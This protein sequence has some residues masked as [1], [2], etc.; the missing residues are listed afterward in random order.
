MEE[1]LSS[2][3]MIMDISSMRSRAIELLKEDKDYHTLLTAITEKDYYYD[4]SIGL[5]SIKELV[6]QT[7]VK[8]DLIRKQL[9]QIYE[10]LL[11]LHEA[12]KPFQ[13]HKVNFSFYIKGYKNVVFMETN[14]L[15]VMPRVGESTEIPFFKA[16]LGGEYF[17]VEKIDH[18]LHD[19]CHTIQFKL[20]PGEYNIYWH[21][22]KDKAKE[23]GE[24]DIHDLIYESDFSLKKKLNIGKHR[25]W[26]IS[27]GFY[28]NSTGFLPKFTGF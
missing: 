11:P 15:S 20:K 4:D 13:F 8:Y 18:I 7:G 19:T 22:Q 17:Y 23:E 16:Y 26:K 10:D 28:P 5:P 1:K 24:F 25:N 21:Y 14:P 9:K 3:E 12:S 27:T 2:K 6:E